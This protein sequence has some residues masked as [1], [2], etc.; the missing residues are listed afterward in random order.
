MRPLTPLLHALSGGYQLLIRSPLLAV[1][2]VVAQCLTYLPVVMLVSDYDFKEGLW[3]VASVLVSL[4]TTLLI[5]PFVRAALIGS[6]AQVKQ[7]ARLT[8]PEF[9]AHG[10]RF[11][12]PLLT[13]TLLFM[14]GSLVLGAVVSLLPDTTDYLTYPEVL[15]LGPLLVIPL[16]ELAPIM[17]VLKR[18]RPWPAVVRSYQLVGQYPLE[19][20]S[21][22]VL[23]WGLPSLLSWLVWGRPSVST[24]Y[25]IDR[26]V[27]SLF[28]L[29]LAVPTLVNWSIEKLGPAEQLDAPAQGMGLR[30]SVV[31]VLG[32]V[33]VF[34]VIGSVW[35][36]YRM[37]LS[38]STARPAELEQPGVLIGGD[39]MSR[40][41]LFEDARVGTVTDIQVKRSTAGVEYH[42]AGRQGALVADQQAHVTAF[43]IFDKRG[44]EVHPV[45]VDGDG[46]SEYLN[47]GGHGWQDASLIAHDG[48]TVWRHGGTPGVDDMAAGD[49]D[50]DGLPE[51]VVGMHGSG[52][53]RRLNRS[54]GVD[55]QEADSNVWHVEIIDTDG[56]GMLEIVH[57]NAS[58][59]I[60]VRNQAGAVLNRATPSASDLYMSGFSIATWPHR[61]GQAH[62]LVPRD[63]KVLLV[64]FYGN[65]VVEFVAPVADRYGDIQG[66]HIDSRRDGTGY[67]AVLVN[68]DRHNRAILYLYRPSLEFGDLVYQEILTESSMA[69]A[70]VTLDQTGTDALLVGGSGKVWQYEFQ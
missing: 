12:W 63:G 24:G 50:G 9:F 13:L 61:A 51:F 49:L 69:L 31:M 55:W 57:S 25:E 41:L 32:V 56:D 10:A 42:V 1:L 16:I 38:Q 68:Y 67:F 23:L 46:R 2:A 27:V 40:R 59:Q 17:I 43:V 7:H 34:T 44:S 22:I 8:I 52:G 11:Y 28:F 33:F 19:L 4:F 70:T 29:I 66:L 20:V 35:S 60:T 45:D 47:R 54:G 48:T 14:L 64:D 18:M 37:F 6:Y 15:L 53:V 26:A 65:K 5:Q 30:R 3:L 62:L 39:L 58:G 21:L 36:V